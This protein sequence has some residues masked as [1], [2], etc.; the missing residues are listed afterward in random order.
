MANIK[1]RDIEG[2]EN[3]KAEFDFF[4]C[5]E[6][7]PGW[8]GPE[9]YGIITDLNK[10]QL[11]EKYPS[12]ISFMEPVLLLD[13]SLKEIRNEYR[14]NEKKHTWR[15]ANTM[16]IFGFDDDSFERFHSELIC[17]SFDEQIDPKLRYETLYK[18]L[19]QLTVSQK[20]RIT[21]YYF[22]GKSI[23][24]IAQSEHVA[25]SSVHE[26][27]SAGLKKLKKIMKTPEKMS[28]LTGNI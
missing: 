14:K 16:D 6:E 10:T 15:S 20:R 1:L 25:V 13:G 19:E 12:I 11:L 28:S 26:G 17:D 24:E 22:D 8:T 18:A 27:L 2:Y 3:F 21:A 9:K 4:R 7:Y 5:E 23:E